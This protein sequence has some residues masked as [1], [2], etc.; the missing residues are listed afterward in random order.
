MSSFNENILRILNII[1][2]TVINVVLHTTHE[3]QL[4]SVS[5]VFFSSN[6]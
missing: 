3:F 5:K 4:H 1:L 6:L 2:Y